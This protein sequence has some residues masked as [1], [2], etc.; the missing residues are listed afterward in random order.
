MNRYEDSGVLGCDAVFLHVWFLMFHR[1]AAASSSRAKQFK[2]NA[3]LNP[4][5]EHAVF[6]YSY[7]VSHPRRSESCLHMQDR[8]KKM[9]CLE[10]L[11]SRSQRCAVAIIKCFKK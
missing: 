10:V 11:L 2:K 1:I 6:V 9:Y 5:N 8:N 7:T 3:L 4:G